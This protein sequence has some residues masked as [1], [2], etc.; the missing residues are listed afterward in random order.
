M[1]T[2]MSV[3]CQY[4]WVHFHMPPHAFRA[5]SG[6]QQNEQTEWLTVGAQTGLKENKR[7][8][9]GRGLHAWGGCVR[10]AEFGS[11]C[12]TRGLPHRQISQLIWGF[13]VVVFGKWMKCV[14]LF[15]IDQRKYWL[16]LIHW[17][18]NFSRIENHSKEYSTFASIPGIVFQHFW[19]N[20]F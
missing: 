11:C 16:I 15:I 4:D 1:Y 19:G 2:N 18:T 9:R 3:C 13:L 14:Q 5:L 10:N 8:Y 7:L 17:Q 6:E 20:Y 12:G